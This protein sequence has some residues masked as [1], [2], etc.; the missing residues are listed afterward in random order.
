M[1]CSIVGR[2]Y[3]SSLEMPA[4]RSPSPMYTD[5]NAGPSYFLYTELVVYRHSSAS[6]LYSIVYGS[7]SVAPLGGNHDYIMS[8]GEMQSFIS[9]TNRVYIQLSSDC[10][11]FP[12]SRDF[13]F[14]C[15]C[16][17]SCGATW[18][19]RYRW[20]DGKL[21]LLLGLHNN[22]C[23]ISPA[24]TISRFN[25]QWHIYGILYMFCSISKVQLFCYSSVFCLDYRLI[26]LFLT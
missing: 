19:L 3:V 4:I 6:T 23:L 21:R 12:R 25:V 2:A 8:A 11:Q 20:T 9:L 22:K 1:W 26:P 5:C 18:S 10:S 24:M 14:I 15:P 17:G 16:A 13:S 7:S